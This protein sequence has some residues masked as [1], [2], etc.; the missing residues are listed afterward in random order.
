[1]TAFSS[2]GVLELYK[3]L[4]V[5][6]LDLFDLNYESQKT[7]MG[8][9]IRTQADDI[10]MVLAPR[11]EPRNDTS[12]A[13]AQG[14][15]S[16]QPKLS[17]DDASSGSRTT[18]QARPRVMTRAMTKQQAAVK[19]ALVRLSKDISSIETRPEQWKELQFLHVRWLRWDWC[20]T[21]DQELC[22][23]CGVST[24]HENM[25]CF[26]YMR[27]LIVG[28]ID[29][30][31]SRRKR[32]SK[33]ND[34]ESSNTGRNGVKG[35]D[36]KDVDAKMMGATRLTACSAD[37]DSAGFVERRGVLD[38]ASLSAAANP[39][40]QSR[41]MLITRK[42]LPMSLTKAPHQIQRETLPERGKY[43]P[44]L[45]WMAHQFKRRAV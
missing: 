22:L 44:S 10:E 9:S 7:P 3:T 35:K 40:M 42:V 34:Q 11:H 39:W 13:P 31:V 20:H 21:C 29:P 8:D 33:A 24:H 25:D 26:A 12:T 17:V 30:S 4:M 37:I 16:D 2:N 43:G 14:I 32:S 38:V 28:D 5:S 27:S 23:Q 36:R 45:L 19:R 18:H 1:L 15:S 41:L 6:L